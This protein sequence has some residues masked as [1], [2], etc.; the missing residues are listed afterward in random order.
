MRTSRLT[1][2]L[3]VAVLLAAVLARLAYAGGPGTGGRRVRFS[4]APAGPYLLRIV[5]SPTPARTPDLYVEVRVTDPA[6]QEVLTEPGVVVSA[7]PLDVSAP[8][9]QVLA[10]HDI[11]PIPNEYAAHLAIETPG[12]WRILV[13]VEGDPGVGELSFD[14][15]ISRPTSVAA[16]VAVGAPVVGLL[17][18]VAVFV[19]LQRKSQAAGS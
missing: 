14:D 16:I 6:T 13:H 2:G 4:D 9:L 15:R 8:T 7:S 5:T 18:L 12:S 10:S 17:A 3:F 11:A 19:W 1:T